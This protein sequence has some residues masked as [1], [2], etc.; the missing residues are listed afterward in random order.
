MASQ[1][2]LDK[3]RLRQSYRNL[4]HTDL[5]SAIR[6]DF[7]YKILPIIASYTPVSPFPQRSL[8]E[9]V[10]MRFAVCFL[11]L[12][13]YVCCAGYHAAGNVVKIDA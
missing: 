13:S 8:M 7:P 4:W 12:W 6:I 11:A 9:Q 5:M 2:Y 1:E 10:L 3:M